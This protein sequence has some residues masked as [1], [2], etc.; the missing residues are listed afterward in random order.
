MMRKRKAAFPSKAGRPGKTAP[1][2]D[3]NHNKNQP[4]RQR[5]K[6]TIVWL[7]V[8]G[9]IPIWVTEFLYAWRSFA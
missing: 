4:I 1:K 7:A 5:I 8:R 9:L 3:Q 6:Q 2:T